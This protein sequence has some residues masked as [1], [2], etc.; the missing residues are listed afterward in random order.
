M[1]RFFD[2]Q[3]TLTEFD[4]DAFRAAAAENGMEVV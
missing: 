1:E 3:A 2:A 4:P